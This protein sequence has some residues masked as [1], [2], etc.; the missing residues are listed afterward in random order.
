MNAEA[1]APEGTATDQTS[2]LR[3]PQTLGHSSPFCRWRHF[4]KNRRRREHAELKRLL[5]LSA[6]GQVPSTFGLGLDELRRHAN[7]LVQVYGW[8]VDEVLAVLDIEPAATS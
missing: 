8:S 6:Y 1:A 3:S 2:P 4:D 5:D 7:D